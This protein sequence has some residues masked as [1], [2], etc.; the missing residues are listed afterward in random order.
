LYVYIKSDTKDKVANK[1][2]FLL[3]CNKYFNI[4]D[5]NEV[6]TK[7]D[8]G[9]NNHVALIVFLEVKNNE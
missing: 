3:L 4:I 7:K 1:D 5:K 8:D 6:E 2:E 9:G